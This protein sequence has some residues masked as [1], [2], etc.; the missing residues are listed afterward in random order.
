MHI[1]TK[2][3][4]GKQINWSKAGSWPGICVG[5]ELQRNEGTAWGPPS[6]E[7]AKPLVVTQLII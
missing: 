2:F 3:D 1:R 4:G 7:K 6:W 5:V